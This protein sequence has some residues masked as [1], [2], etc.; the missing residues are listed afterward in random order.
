MQLRV[1]GLALSALI[2]S[3]DHSHVS[4]FAISS[5]QGNSLA[6]RHHQ[7]NTLAKTQLPIQR[8]GGSSITDK[9]INMSSEA[10]PAPPKK[11]VRITALDGIRSLL[12]IHIVLGHFLRF[13]GPS[14]FWL[15]FFAQ[16]SK[17][18]PPSSPSIASLQNDSLVV[19]VAVVVVILIPPPASK[20]VGQYHRGCLFC[21]EWICH[22]IHINRS[23]TACRVAKADRY[24]QSK[25]VVDQNYELLSNALVS[26]VVV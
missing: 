14:D 8:R 25:M 10:A 15:K 6:Q 21:L 22:S 18:L 19:V 13:A 12:C 23:R 5:P 1:I 11:R 9:A 26:P 4:A 24:A 16:V 17:Q 3:I 20:R 7:T 2:V